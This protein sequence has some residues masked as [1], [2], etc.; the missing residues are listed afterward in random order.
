MELIPSAE[1]IKNAIWACGSSKALGPDDFNFNFIKQCWTFIG[2][3]LVDCVSIFFVSSSLPRGAIMT[4]VSLAPKV[5]DA[6]EV[7][8][9][10]P[11]N[12]IG[13]ICKII[14]KVL[15]NRLTGV[16][17]GLVGETQTTFM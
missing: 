2:S 7:K 10:C 12:M 3:D 14:A 15:A 9:Y 8:D 5:D 4:W 11:I 13:C 16:M 6:K 1:E 17:D